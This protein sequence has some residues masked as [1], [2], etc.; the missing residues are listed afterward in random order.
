MADLLKKQVQLN[1]MYREKELSVAY[2]N[3]FV[4]N[5]EGREVLKDLLKM[6][7]FAEKGDTLIHMAMHNVAIEILSKCGIDFDEI[8]NTIGGIK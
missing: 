6:L 3:T 8:L 2:R 1:Q 5:E 7:K 4:E